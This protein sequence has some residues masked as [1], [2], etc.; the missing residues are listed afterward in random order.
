LAVLVF[1]ASSNAVDALVGRLASMLDSAYDF[2]LEVDERQIV[3]RE[4]DWPFG[5]P[6]PG[7]RM[8]SLVTRVPSFT[9]QA[10]AAYWRDVHAH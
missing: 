4:R 6:T 3:T 2:V 1:T 8:V 9:R 10:F 7:E 5:T